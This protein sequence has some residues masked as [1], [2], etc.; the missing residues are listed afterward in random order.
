MTY[1]YETTVEAAER[2]LRTQQRRGYR[3][4]VLCLNATT[5]EIRTWR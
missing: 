5:F 2:Y 4:Y 3:G 1:H